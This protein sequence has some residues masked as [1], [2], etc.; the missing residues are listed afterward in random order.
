[1]NDKSTERLTSRS[2]VASL[3]STTLRSISIPAI[4]V[5]PNVR[6]RND[7]GKTPPLSSQRGYSSRAGSAQNDEFFTIYC[8]SRHLDYIVY[9]DY[10]IHAIR[11]HPSMKSFT[12]QDLQ[13]RT[14]EVQEAALVEPIMITHHGRK[15]HVMMSYSA[16][17]DLNRVAEARVFRLSELDQTLLEDL[18]NAE[19]DARHDPLNTLTE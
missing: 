10:I 2:S 5:D 8:A 17:E 11:K 19:M 13:K 4:A 3:V 6:A 9:V 7:S 12:S 18:A 1:M 14:S 16:F 15:R